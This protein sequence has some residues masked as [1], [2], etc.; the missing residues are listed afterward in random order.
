MPVGQFWFPSG[1]QLAAILAGAVVFSPLIVVGTSRW[2]RRD[3]SGIISPNMARDGP[4]LSLRG[5]QPPPAPLA[6][7]KNFL[8]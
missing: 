1:R 7:I 6:Q 8:H 3:I 5:Y 2:Y 4:G